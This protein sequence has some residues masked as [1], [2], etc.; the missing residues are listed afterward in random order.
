MGFPVA[1]ESWTRDD[2][3]NSFSFFDVSFST[4]EKGKNCSQSRSQ[5]SL[6]EN[7]VLYL[8][9]CRNVAAPLTVSEHGAGQIVLR[10]SAVPVHDEHRGQRMIPSAR[11]EPRRR[12]ELDRLLRVL[13]PVPGVPEIRPKRSEFSGSETPTTVV[14]VGF[15]SGPVGAAERQRAAIFFRTEPHDERNRSNE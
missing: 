3:S 6:F 10:H 5:P 12:G 13:G 9:R 11:V 1:L 2:R 14:F 15:T 8:R 7:G 4:N